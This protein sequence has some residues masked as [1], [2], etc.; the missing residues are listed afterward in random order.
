MCGRFTLTRNAQAVAAAFDAAPRDADFGPR[1]NVAPTQPVFAVRPAVAG[2]EG[3]MLRW[4]F[5]PPWQGRSGP[6]LIN[7]M[8]ETAAVKPAFRDAFASRRCLVPADGFYEWLAVGGAKR[9][10]LFSRRDGGLFAFAGLWQHWNGGGGE[11]LTAVCVLTVEA[12]D[13]VRPVHARMPAILA[14]E[15]HDAWLD[16]TLES[17]GRLRHLLVPYPADLM[18][19]RAVV[20]RVNSARNEGP[21]CA[22]PAPEPPLAGPTQ[23]S[24]F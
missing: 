4:G 13:L 11:S 17:A 12:N 24:L 5:V 7:A 2:R 20:T 8:A 14:R 21:S 19:A 9:P 23:L 22:A 3:V 10:T 15:G 18:A 1:F 16:P 6:P